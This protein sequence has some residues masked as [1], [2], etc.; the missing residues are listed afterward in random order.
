M[1]LVRKDFSR[2][3][4]QVFEQAFDTMQ[5]LLKKYYLSNCAENEVR[6]G[7]TKQRDQVGGNNAN[8]GMG[9]RTGVWAVK[10]SWNRLEKAMQRIA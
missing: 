5:M 3:E 7:S 2:G 1:I 4:S 9:A 6:W 8:E 10:Q